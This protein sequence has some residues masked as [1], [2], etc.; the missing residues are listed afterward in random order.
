MAPMAIVQSPPTPSASMIES[1]SKWNKIEHR[2]FSFITQNWRGR[3]LLTHAAIVSL[4]GSTTNRGG[5][6]VTCR[7]DQQRYPSGVKISKAQM[8]TIRLD[9]HAFHGEG[10]YPIHPHDQEK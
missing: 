8:T 4:I 3:P 10:N 7:L 9:P 2:L 6:K 5:L 1:T